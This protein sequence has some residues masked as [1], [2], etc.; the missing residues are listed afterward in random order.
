[1]NSRHPDPR[2]VLGGFRAALDATTSGD[3]GD[4]ADSA[5]CVTNRAF[6]LFFTVLGEKLAL[7]RDV[8]LTFYDPSRAKHQVLEPFSDKHFPTTVS[9][10]VVPRGRSLKKSKKHQA[11]SPSAFSCDVFLTF[12]YPSRVKH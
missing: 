6:L 1:M 7:S 4:S 9:K 11:I 5:D 3:S 2:R 12:C 8:F 10:H